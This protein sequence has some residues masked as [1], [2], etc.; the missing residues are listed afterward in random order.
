MILSDV[1]IRQAMI[2]GDVTIV[3]AFK[4]AAQ[5]QPASFDVTLSAIFFDPETK[6]EVSLEN[7]NLVLPPGGFILGATREVI[8]LSNRLAAQLE[9]RSS[10]GR[11]GISVHINA[12]FIDPGFVGCL[13]LCIKNHSATTVSLKPGMRIAQLIFHELKTPCLNAYDGRY[14]GQKGPGTAK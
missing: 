1:D 6:A 2:D 5:I 4:Y 7:R 14:Q 12:G 9:G 11:Q 3:S 13:T 10:L 8:S